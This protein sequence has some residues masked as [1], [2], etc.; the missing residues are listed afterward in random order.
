MLYAAARRKSLRHPT[1]HSTTHRNHLWTLSK[2]RATHSHQDLH[3][4]LFISLVMFANCK[5]TGIYQILNGVAQRLQGPT[6]FNRAS[7]QYRPYALSRRF[8]QPNHRINMFSSSLDGG[9]K[10]DNGHGRKFLS[11]HLSA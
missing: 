4:L 5:Q 11:V 7:S 8:K 1:P 10:R 3:R 6:L 9:W 2:H